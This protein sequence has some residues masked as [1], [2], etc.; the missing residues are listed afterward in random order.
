MELRQQ[1]GV[2]RSWF[3]LLVASVLLAGGAAY[4]VS[5]NLPKV[6]EG[7][8]TLIVGQS[9]QAA[10]PDLNQLLASQ[11][12][13]QTYADLATT[14]PAAPA[15]HRQ[16]RPRRSRRRS[17]AKRIVADAPRDSTL[18]PPDRPGWRPGARGDPRELPGGRDD[19]RLAGD[20]RPRHRRSSSSSTRDLAAIQAQIEEHPG[21][22]PA[23]DQPAVALGQRRAAAAGPPGPDRHPPPD[24]RHDARLLV[25]QRREPAHRRRPGLAA[26]GRRPR[27]A[28]CSTRSSPRSSGC[29]SP[30][31]SSSCSSTSTTPS[32]RPTTWRRWSGCRP[33][34]R[35]SKM[36]GGKGQS[37]IY[38]LA[39][40]LYPRSPVAEAY[41]SLRTNIEFAAVDAPVQDAPRH[42]LR[43]RARARR[44][45]PRTS[46]SSSP[47]PAAG[48]S[49]WTRTS[50][51]RASIG[52]STCRTP[53][54]CRACCARMRRRSTT[55]PRPP[56]RRTC[57][58]SPPGRSR[59]TLPSCWARSG[60]GRSWAASSTPRTSS[61]STAR[62]SRP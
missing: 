62:R 33:W 4:L 58:S 41:R 12:L 19:R 35:S 14:R 53:T 51:S 8:V 56:S 45:P 54:A 52:S 20:R 5:S 49:C 2:L 18:R 40:L 28:S 60:C 10:N 36:Q 6:Y 13:S 23:A 38:R 31:A 57:G 34:A 7:K 21:R 15:G 17:S 44:R 22:D 46:R 61:S 39:T 42:Q 32:S 1:L 55:S 9:I 48:R 43:S 25:E 59:R 29:S 11:R 27:R 30:S 16:E 24:L 47:R 50:A 26:T 3:W 37:E